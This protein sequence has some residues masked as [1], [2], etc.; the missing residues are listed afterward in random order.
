MSRFPLFSSPSEG[1][2]AGSIAGLASATEP[3]TDEPVR[4]VIDLALIG[5]VGAGKTELAATIIRTLRARAPELEAAEAADNQ[6]A[7]RAVVGGAAI[8]AEPG[9]PRVAHYT[10]RTPVASLVEMLPA[11][12]RI[13]VLW[14]AGIARPPVGPALVIAA[15]A[16]AAAIGLPGPFHVVA[17][18]AAAAVI[19]LLFASAFRVAGA[20]LADAGEVELV[21]WDPPGELLEDE[22]AAEVYDLFARLTRRR[23]AVRPGWRGYAFVPALVLDPTRFAGDRE[24]QGV[25]RLRGLLPMF[26]ALGGRRP[27][28]VVAINRWALIAAACP[29]GSAKAAR[30]A[31]CVES[32]GAEPAH[33]ELDR[34]ALTR[35]CVEAEDGRDGGLGLTHLRYE[36][37]ADVAVERGEDGLR[38]RAAGGGG[39]MIG[40]ARLRLATLLAE[41]AFAGRSPA[42]EPARVATAA[43][44][45]PRPAPSDAA[46]AHQV[47]GDGEAVTLP[48]QPTGDNARRT[49][50]AMTAMVDDGDRPRRDT[51]RGAA[52]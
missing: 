52:P 8:E 36:A 3:G 44:P 16:A 29:P 28:A 2:G 13:A 14:R 31:V 21:I 18:L 20:H 4:A 7:L 43:P 47:L 50:A 48:Y 33:L 9:E 37:S 11:A 40:E 46:M 30:A 32:G 12:A 19:A 39:T 17:P 51:W 23:R 15:A 45:P 1:S 27:R 34:D 41:L 5:E 22:R 25:G 24:R 38:Y 10:F 42:P 49:L 6:R 35:D 26:A